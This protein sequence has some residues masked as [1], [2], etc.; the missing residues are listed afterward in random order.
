MLLLLFS[1]TFDPFFATTDPSAILGTSR[2]TLSKAE[3]HEKWLKEARIGEH[4][5][6]TVEYGIHSF[7]Y[8]SKRSFHPMRLYEVLFGS[9]ERKEKPFD[10]LLRGKGFCW[11]APHSEFQGIFAYAGGKSSMVAGSLWWA[12]RFLIVCVFV[13]QAV[14]YKNKKYVS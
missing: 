14:S 6:E 11:L 5:P 9:M 1:T 2:F 8:R 13:R 4:V 12:V 3:E 10:T 7:T